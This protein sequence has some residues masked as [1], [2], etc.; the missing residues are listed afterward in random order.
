[1]IKSFKKFNEAVYATGDT[2]DIAQRLN[3]VNMYLGEVGLA[4]VPLDNVL[5][6]MHTVLKHEYRKQKLT[7]E[8]IEEIETLLKRVTSRVE[9]S[10]KILSGNVDGI[11]RTDMDKDLM[12]LRE[13]CGKTS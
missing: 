5:G 8:Q 2:F 6:V 10:K 13:L 1:M 4:Y 9:E 7:V 11:N 3:D 12:R